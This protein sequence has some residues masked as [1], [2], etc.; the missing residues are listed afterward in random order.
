MP[1]SLSLRKSVIPPIMI[2]YIRRLLWNTKDLLFHLPVWKA[3]K[4][5]YFTRSREPFSYIIPVYNEQDN[6]PMLFE[7]VRKAMFELGESLDLIL[8]DYGSHDW[9]NEKDH[10]GIEGFYD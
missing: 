4:P 3:A 7:A 5:G 1:M 9:Q 2:F 6:L 8:I 10:W